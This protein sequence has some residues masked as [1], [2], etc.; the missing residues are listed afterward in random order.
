MSTEANSPIT[1]LFVT[2]SHEDYARLSGI[3]ADCFGRLEFQWK[4]QS[5]GSLGSAL[6]LMRDQRVPMVL[7]E[8][9]MG[10]ESWKDLLEKSAEFPHG[11][12]VIVTSRTADEHLWSEALNRGAY[13]VLSMPFHTEE[14]ERVLHS[15]WAHWKDRT[16]PA[17]AAQ[18]SAVA[19]S[20]A[21]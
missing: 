9:K 7:C 19:V 8:E 15:A 2:T 18:P 11:P 12:S 10:G 13:D 6:R 5:C 14:V 1:L 21:P 17:E 20:A 3:L 16:R 4:L